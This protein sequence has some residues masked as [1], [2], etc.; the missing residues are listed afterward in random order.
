MTLLESV[1]EAG[2]ECMPSVG[3]AKPTINNPILGWTEH[4]KPYQE[5]SRFW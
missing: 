4:Y 3:G 2:K 1:E 5:E